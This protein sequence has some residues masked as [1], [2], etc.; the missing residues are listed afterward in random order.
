PA[1]PAPAAQVVPPPPPPPQAPPPPPPAF[2]VVVTA[3]INGQF[4]PVVC[5]DDP[6]AAAFATVAAQLAAEPDTLAFDAG[7]LLGPSAVTRLTV[8]HDVDAFTA[9]VAASGIRVMAFGHRDLSADRAPIVAGLR[10]LRARN[11]RHVL[12]NLHCDPTHRELCEV[13][14]DSD[15]APVQFD[16][17][18][19]RVALIAMVDPSALT[20]LAR[21][22][23]A[24]LTLD[25]LDEAL[26]RAVT[27]ARAAGAMHVVVVIDPRAR[28]EVE[29]AL[30]LAELF[31]PGQ[32]PDAMVVH[33][34][35]AGTAAIL[36]ARSGVPVV[37]TRP[38]NAVVLEPGATRVSRA[39]RS[40]EAPAGVTS[41][42]NSTRQWLCSTYAQPLAGGR[43]TSELSRDAF[44]GLMLD[45]WRDLAE[46]DV[47]I[48]NRGA[49]RQPPGLFPI[50]GSVTPLTIAAALPF[51]DSL[52]VARVT[53]AV[54]KALATSARAGSFYLRGVVVDGGAVKINGRLV[55]DAQQ[56]RIITTGYIATGGDGGAGD[57]IDYV[58]FAGGSAQDTFLGWLRTP[59]EG[60]IT[61]APRDPADH[62]RWNFRWTTDVGFNST[63]IA[64]NPFVG[65]GLTYQDPQLSRA[66]SLNLR[67]DTLVR[68]DADN[69]YFTWDNGLRLQYGRA[70]VT[71]SPS[72]GAPTPTTG[73]FD[74]NLD[75][76]SYN[77]SVAWR[78]FRGERKWFHPLPVAVGFV[79]TEIDG[80]PTPRSPDYHHLTLRPTVGARFELLERMTLNLTAGMNWIESLAPSQVTG[81]SPEF[82]IVGSLVAR[83]GT[84][85]TLGGRNIDGG[86]SIEYTLSDPGASDSQIVR[87][88]G[89]LSIPLFQPL[90]LTL[91]YDLYARTVNGQAWGLGHDTTIGLR[92]A[93][94]R[95]VQLF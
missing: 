95:S 61:H 72:M 80:P 13:V 90:Q 79:E 73:P 2:R 86:F 40:G 62:T 51:E 21:D 19:G 4:S 44:A 63:T 56:Y 78:W 84:L 39:A 92:I 74:E 50:R 59:R 66:Q 83:P 11:L 17:P 35:P 30:A 34:L 18:A 16:S 47:A 53:G 1:T 10:A 54:L 23:S 29:Q 6:P 93:F 33:D 48:I 26:P 15:D 24:G 71:P 37:S 28:H 82:A 43:L 52:H 58:R 91:G 94:S 75:L 12:S 32:G 36:T 27:A 41:F 85:F 88:S 68:A 70:S 77:T 31:E 38:G 87:A 14:E 25:P 3:G 46:A 5:G 7:D 60:D 76:I 81:S 55:D 42:V 49:V 20:L 57:D 22:R 65:M 9:A 67:I 8:Q 69:P 45:V 64:N 89:R